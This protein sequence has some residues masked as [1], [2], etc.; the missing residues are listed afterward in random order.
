MDHLSTRLVHAGLVADPGF[1]SVIPAVHQTST[2]KQKSP[3]QFVDQFDYS[4]SANPTRA[5]LE[6]ALGEIEGGWGRAFASG[7][8]ASHAVLAALTEAGEKIILPDDL[9]GGTY[10]LVDQVLSRF[11]LDY[12]LVD[13]TD[14]KSLEKA[15]Q[16][17][18]SLLWIESP[19][20]PLLRTVDLKKAIDLAH[21]YRARVAV[22]N[23]FA[24]PVFQRPIELGADIV[25][26]STT[27]YLGG[28]SDTVG[29]AVI[30]RTEEL[31][32]KIAFIQNAV[33]SVPGPWDCF[34]VHRGMRTLYLRM[35]A[36]QAN[37]KQIASWLKEQQ[38]VDK[39][40]YPGFGGML[41]FTHPKAEEIVTK[42]RLFTLAES[43]G[44]VESLIEIPAQMTHI[45]V[46]QS[47]AKV[48]D[49]L[50]RLSPGIE[51]STDLIKDLSQAF[52][53]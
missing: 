21:H 41:S 37:A 44:G 52:K 18:A 6:K 50:V 26:H 27:K 7:M 45:S 3:G 1:G 25:V 40:Y 36:H 14:L 13:Q 12:Q 11:G 51:D 47:E 49:H 34:L 5:A 48:P 46:S 28:H 22:D 53:V 30:S 42:T 2:Y 10:R 9:Y 17:G 31:D 23:T 4:R 19:T 33:G 39:V 15:L 20:N 29:G 32:Q 35:Q 24:T 38:E 16:A 8:A 43:L